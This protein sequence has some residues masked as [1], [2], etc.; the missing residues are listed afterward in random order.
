L[1]HGTSEEKEE[2]KQMNLLDFPQLCCG[3]RRRSLTRVNAK[4]GE[5]TYHPQPEGWG[6]RVHPLPM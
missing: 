3:V 1:Q 4:N 6:I 5:G 2:Y